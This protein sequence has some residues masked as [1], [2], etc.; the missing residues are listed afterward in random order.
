MKI[1]FINHNSLRC[2]VA[3]YG[4]RVFDILKP[5]MDIT[6]AEITYNYQHDGS[7]SFHLYDLILVNYHYATL[8]FLQKIYGIKTV[9]LYHE[10]LYPDF[11]DKVIAVQDLPR[12]LLENTWFHRALFPPLPVIGSFG[13]GFPD[14]NFPRICELVKEQYTEAIILLN[15]PFAEFGD[16]DGN[17]ARS[18]ADKCREILAGTNIGIDITHDYKSPEDLLCWLSL[19]DINLFLYKPSHGRG[20]SSTIDYA[21]SVKRP[22]GVSNSEMFRHLP[23]EICVD[24]ISIPDLIKQGIEPLRKVYEDNSNEKFVSKIKELIA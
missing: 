4:R 3:D 20:I 16:N 24:N 19:N 21:L 15:I 7:V 6:Y 22:I 8:P 13:F 17:L 5:H 11:F 18:E 23:R 12:P 10:A 9:A 14:K 2:G 1:L